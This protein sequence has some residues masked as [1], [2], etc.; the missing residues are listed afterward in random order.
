MANMEESPINDED[1]EM[2]YEHLRKVLD[3]MVK[4]GLVQVVGIGDDGE[5]FY[6]AT[7]K[8]LEYYRKSNRKFG[9]S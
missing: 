3:E 9:S 5:W 4:D 8:G 7:D 6:A 1:N 2:L